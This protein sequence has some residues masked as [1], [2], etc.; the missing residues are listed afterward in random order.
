ME[1][2]LLMEQFLMRRSKPMNQMSGGE[3]AAT[4]EYIEEVLTELKTMGVK[5]E[6]D[7]LVYLLGMAKD[8][9]ANISHNQMTPNRMERELHSRR[10]K[11]A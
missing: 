1:K 7:F 3:R 10:P 2:P 11:S 9:A 4:A 5:M 8:E 6:C